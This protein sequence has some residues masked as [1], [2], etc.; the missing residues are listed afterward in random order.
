[1]GRVKL[2]GMDRRRLFLLLCLRGSFHELLGC[3]FVPKDT[4]HQHFWRPPWF[5]L[6]YRMAP[7][8][9]VPA[10]RQGRRRILKPS[11]SCRSEIRQAMKMWKLKMLR[12]DSSRFDS[13]KW[14]CPRRIPQPTKGSRQ[15]LAKVR[16]RL[17]QAARAAQPST[18]QMQTR[19]KRTA[20]EGVKNEDMN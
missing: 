3:L 18:S 4:L 20:P 12:M 9:R 7:K 1:M 17:R 15:R 19:S 14:E 6:A 10:L 11:S 2:F 16:T 8:K 13:S 5:G